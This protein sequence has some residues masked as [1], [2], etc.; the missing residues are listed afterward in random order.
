MMMYIGGSYS[1]ESLVLNRLELF[2]EICICVISLHLLFFTD[3]LSVEMQAKC[4]WSMIICTAV[5]I[6]VDLAFVIK[7]GIRMIYLIAK[8]YKI[9]YFG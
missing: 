7:Y 6:T 4:G 9:R 3:W 1:L 2:N 8:K 5:L